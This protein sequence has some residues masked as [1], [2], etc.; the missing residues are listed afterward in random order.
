MGSSGPHLKTGKLSPDA[1]RRLVLGRLGVRRPEV[2]VHAAFGED[3]AAIGV[4]DQAIVLTADPITGAGARAGWYAVHVCCNDLAAMGAEPIG[5]LVTLLMPEGCTEA[6]VA[7]LMDDVDA[8]ARELGVEVLGGHTE[9]AP[10]VRAPILSLAG[11]GRAP[12]D[13]LLRSSGGRPGQDLLLTKAAALE[14]TAIL[15]ADLAERLAGRVPPD[16][17]ERARGFS[18]ELSVVRDPPEADW[19]RSWA[20]RRCTTRPRAACSAPSGS[21]LR[22]PASASSCGRSGCR[23]ARRRAP[24][25]PRWAPTRCG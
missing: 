25:A 11:V 8:A 9:V 18:A 23:S 10:G 20:P 12:R 7:A 13:R 19:R 6:D 14:G 1:L 16:V 21:W 22:R 24:S 17:L 2:L 5:V 3:A 15:A 4:D